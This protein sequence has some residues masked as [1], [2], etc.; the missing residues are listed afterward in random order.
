MFSLRNTL[1]NRRLPRGYNINMGVAVLCG[2]RPVSITRLRSSPC[3]ESV[4]VHFES[5]LQ[6]NNNINQFIDEQ[7][8]AM[9]E[10]ICGR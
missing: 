3:P 5:L 7:F 4:I 8:L 9:P 2:R 10:A 6:I 1:S